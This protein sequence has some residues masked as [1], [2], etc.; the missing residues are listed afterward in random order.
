MTIIEG[1]LIFL[2]IVLTYFA[3]V[4]FLKKK[5]I[6][7]KYNMSLYGPLLMIRTNKGK[8]LIEKIAEKKRFWKAFGSFGVVYCFIV[9]IIMV[10]VFIWQFWFI[11][12]LEL[13]PLQKAG[14][15][16]P[17]MALVLPG[18]NPL[19]PLGSIFYIV[20]AL[21]VAIIVHEFS[22]GI[23][24]IVSKLKVKS[25]GLLLLTIIPMGAF[26]EPDEEGLKKTKRTNRMRVYAAGPMSNFVV[27]F[28]I[29]FL[30]SFVFMSAVQ[31]ID[32]TEILY[33]Y[34][35][36]PADEIGL[37]AGT[38]ITSINDT[39]VDTISD[40][41]YVIGEIE[42]YHTVNISYLYEGKTVHTQVNLTSLF[43]YTQNESHKNLSFL[44]IGFN[45]IKDDYV[46]SLKNPFM[47][48]FPNGFL[49]AY[50]LPVAGFYSGYNPLNSPFTD[51]F[52]ITGPLGILPDGI[53]WGIVNALYWIFWL[54]LLVGM[55]NVLPIIPFDG[56]FLYLDALSSLVK[57]IKKDISEE[58]RDFIV[59]NITLITSLIILFMVIFPFFFKYI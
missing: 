58:K 32:G 12:G 46:S 26:C 49:N 57:R 8:K 25:L 31:P 47:Y 3:I 18:L 29:L 2:S 51:N 24:T 11:I 50:S 45:T 21:V 28:A 35:G 39:S 59:K 52:E 30:F 6:L 36:T 7:E 53:F 1:L 55:F 38:L 4:L 27:A 22:H 10:I 9:M 41:G 56:G 5:N 17:E 48:D 13:T 33:A 34:E 42:P 20:L 23:L 15:P 37:S 19:L 54:N 44:G 14:L 16:G 40:C 43:N